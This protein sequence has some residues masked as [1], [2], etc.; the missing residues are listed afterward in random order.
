M[1]AVLVA[2]LESHPEIGLV[3]SDWEVIDE[4]GEVLGTARTYEYDPYIL[5]RTNYINA[6]FLYR[7][8]CQDAVGYYD[9]D[10][11]HAEDWEYWLR[12]SRQFKMM[13][14]PEVLYQY[15]IHKSSL[16]QTDVY[17]QARRES[18]GYRKI[19]E[20]LRHHRLAWY[21]SKL[22]WECLRFRES[23]KPGFYIH[24]IGRGA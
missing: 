16:T 15:R 18:A 24:G 6:S 21:Y 17:T 14:V 10:F 3:Y 13:H 4:R 5:M 8:A 12:I 20:E 1:L 11:L 2:A 19:R 23:N 22:R 9:P 7:R